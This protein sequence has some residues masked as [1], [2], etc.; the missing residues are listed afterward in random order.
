MKILVLALTA[1]LALGASACAAAPKAG[2]TAAQKFVPY[3]IEGGYFSCEVPEGWSQE[4]S[5]EQ[6]KEYNIFEV[7]LLGPGGKAPTSIFVSYYSADNEDFTDHENFIARNSRNALGQTKGRRETYQ[8]VKKARLAGREAFVLEREKQAFLH[9]QS[10]SDESVQLK[11]K[12]YVLPAKPGFY[13]LHF[14]AEKKAF[15]KH[16]ASFE[17]AAKSF[18]G[19]F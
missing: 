8:P 18:S 1:A 13:V 16:L 15:D 11:E 12:L 5:P 7:Q 6:D 17:R 4:R 14:S 2:K 9:P 10:K 19:K 3:A